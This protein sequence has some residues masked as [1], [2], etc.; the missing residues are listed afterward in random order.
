MYRDPVLIEVP[1]LNVCGE[2]DS[3]FPMFCFLQDLRKFSQNR[4]RPHPCRNNIEH[5]IAQSF[6]KV[7]VQQDFLLGTKTAA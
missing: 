3:I 7:E 1:I 4:F 2:T 6:V 5:R